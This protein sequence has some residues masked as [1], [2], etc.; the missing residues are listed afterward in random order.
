MKGREK[1]RKRRR[2]CI[3]A[4]AMAVALGTLSVGM[5]AEA[6]WQVD[7]RGW[8]WNDNGGYPANQWKNIDGS[9]YWFEGSG[10][11][12]TGWQWIDGSWYYM[13]GSG[14]MTTGWQWADGAWYYLYE[15]GAMAS[16]TWIGNYFLRENGT[17]ATNQ[18]IGKDYVGN[19]GCWVPGKQPES[20]NESPDSKP[21]TEPEEKPEAQPEYHYELKIL[22]TYDEL[23]TENHFATPIVYIKTDN[24]DE[25][26]I[27]VVADPEINASLVITEYDDVQG[28]S[29]DGNWLKVD[30]GFL[31]HPMAETAGTYTLRV[32]E[33]LEGHEED[34]FYTGDLRYACK[35]D[36][37]LTIDIKDYQKSYEA[38]IQSLINKY[39][40]SKMTPKEKFEAVVYGEFTSRNGYR[41]DPVM[42]DENGEYYKVRLLKDEGTIW[43]N[44]RLNSSNS[45]ALLE[46]I[47]KEVGYEVKPISWDLSNPLHAYVETPEG[48]ILTICPSTYTGE[49]TNVD[50]VNFS[51]Y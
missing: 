38:W 20:G 35:T 32:Y 50:Y 30:G 12:T 42:K 4:M 36:V 14:A 17:M 47:G 15:S 43:Q 39:T 1:G 9:W 29:Y 10:Y 23:Y 8:W 44:H 51:K 40:T 46:R 18:W 45:P 22:N 19:D 31:Y 11:M 33:I 13:N 3:T 41:Y 49:V 2:A 27:T 28:S 26:R 37:T 16:N 48:D 24:P 25:D 21:D 34:Y 7:E 6:G 5:Q